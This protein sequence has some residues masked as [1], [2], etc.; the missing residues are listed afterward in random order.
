MSPCPAVRVRRL[1]P[2]SPAQLL[3]PWPPTSGPA[4]AFPSAHGGAAQRGL[5]LPDLD[6]RVG[7]EA[8][9]ELLHQGLH[10]LLRHLGSC[11]TSTG[12]V[13]RKEHCVPTAHKNLSLCKPE[14]S[15]GAGALPTPSGVTQGPIRHFSDLT[16]AIETRKLRVYRNCPFHAP[17]QCFGL[18]LASPPRALGSVMSSSNLE[19][20]RFKSYRAPSWLWVRF[21]STPAAQN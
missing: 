10:R 19:P 4:A 17:F 20:E 3:W 5:Q 16:K 21:N 13:V 14:S 12:A 9:L 11:N 2:S 15:P 7:A 18:F 8:L 6:G 1:P